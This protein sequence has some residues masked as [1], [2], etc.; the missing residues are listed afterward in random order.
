ME[1]RYR[2]TACRSG[3]ACRR[4]QHG[5]STMPNVN[6]PLQLHM[7][8]E[9]IVVCWRLERSSLKAKHGPTIGWHLG[10]SMCRLNCFTICLRAAIVLLLFRLARRP[11]HLKPWVLA[12]HHAR[13]AHH[14]EARSRVQ[15]DELVLADEPR[16]AQPGGA[17]LNIGQVGTEQAGGHTPPSVC[18]VHAHGMDGQQVCG[19]GRIQANALACKLC[20]T[21]HGRHKP[22]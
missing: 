21:V 13:G 11:A 22:A 9:Y 16:L 8:H 4:L 7:Q 1:L 15:R 17:G 5:A 6:V 10:L 20:T 3:K 19:E 2:W 14:L 12:V 18:S